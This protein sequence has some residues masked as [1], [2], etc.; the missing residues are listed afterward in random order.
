MNGLR[1]TRRKRIQ[2]KLPKTDDKG[3]RI[4]SLKT[5]NR[6]SKIELFIL[7]FLFYK[8]FKNGKNR[9]PHI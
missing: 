4:N 2:R 9:A 8:R 5:E 7:R 6:E 1:K 3:R